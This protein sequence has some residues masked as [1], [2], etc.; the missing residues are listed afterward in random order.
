[1]RSFIAL[2]LLAALPV[3]A[4]Y[5]MQTPAGEAPGPW[6]F[7]TIG[8]GK[9]G[10][11][12][13]PQTTALKGLAIK[14]GGNGES[15]IAYDLQLC[16]V[17]GAWTGGK[18][19][20]PMNLMSR[21]QS[22]TALGQP[23][24]VTGEVNGFAGAKAR[25]RGLHVNEGEQVIEW[26]LDG[27]QLLEMPGYARSGGVDRLIRRFQAE[28]GAAPFSILLGPTAAEGKALKVFAA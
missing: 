7:G 5:K 21:G 6:L 1:M 16:R 9:A 14:L 11:G 12:K 26:E 8:V 3:T 27:K 4:Q 18:F 17:A 2:F 23:L 19:V 25:F 28:P 15:G 13:A 10:N 20:T 24:F 22:P